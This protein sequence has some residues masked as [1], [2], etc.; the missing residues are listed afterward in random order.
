VAQEPRTA[1]ERALELLRLT[2]A[3]P[4]WLPTTNTKVERLAW[5]IR[6]AIVLGLV[7]LIASAV[8]KTLWDWLELL[9]IPVVLALGGY[10]F[11]RSENQRRDKNAEDQ[12]ALDRELA[13][14]RRQDDTLQAYLDGMSELLTDKDRPLHRARPGDSL[15]SVAR[16][17][18][19]TVLPGLDGRRKG[20][21]VR[22]LYEAALIHKNAAVFLLNGADLSGVDLGSANLSGVNLRGFMLKESELRL[23]TGT[24]TSSG[25]DLTDLSKADLDFADLF[26]A[27]LTLTNLQSASLTLANLSESNLSEANLQ[28]ADMLAANLRGANLSNARLEGARLDAADLRNA[29]GMDNEKLERQAKSLERATMPN[30][31]SYEDWLKSKGSGEDGENSGPS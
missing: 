11:T 29:E 15:S 13:D 9:I 27:E 30:G 31:Q 17:R 5:A 18:T 26:G 2:L 1:Q 19:L 28:E 23:A 10:L 4:R 12:R 25:S 14:E 3:T 21:V 20:R 16:A 7:V 8:D 24:V 6:G 22:F